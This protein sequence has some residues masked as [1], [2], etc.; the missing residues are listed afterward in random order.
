MTL[1]R[2]Q[3]CVLYAIIGALAFAGT[4]SQVLEPVRQ[5]GFVEGTLRFWSD[6]MVNESS[7]FIAIDILFLGLAVFVW[8]ILEA[9]RLQLPGVWLYIAG[10]LLIGISLFVP[11]FLIHRERRQAALDGASQAGVVGVGD[12]VG[13]AILAAAALAY[14]AMVVMH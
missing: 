6:L 13:F 2:S 14:A 4:W 11:L 7:R 1:S 3:L 12:V 5:L 8:M 9:R 10:S